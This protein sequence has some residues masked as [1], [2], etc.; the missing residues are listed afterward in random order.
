LAVVGDPARRG[1]ELRALRKA[2]DAVAELD[3][4]LMR[5]WP[6]KE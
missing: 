5:L 6:L 2:L 4:Q 1:E 3:R